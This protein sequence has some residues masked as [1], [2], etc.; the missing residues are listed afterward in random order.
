MLHA[1]GDSRIASY[2]SK[3]NHYHQQAFTL[4]SSVVPFELTVTVYSPDVGSVNFHVLLSLGETYQS[5][6]KTFPSDFLMS[7]T[8]RIPSFELQV[9]PT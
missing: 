9:V 4:T 1:I 7:W 3:V 2:L 8:I 6:D 5:F